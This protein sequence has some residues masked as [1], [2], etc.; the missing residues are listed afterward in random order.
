[1]FQLFEKI[2]FYRGQ[3]IAWSR[4]IFGNTKHRLEVNQRALK[5]LA[6]RGYNNNLEEISK[7]K[8]EINELLHQEEGFYWQRYRAIWLPAGDKNTKLFHRR[9]S[10]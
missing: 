8:E 3:L 10:Q 9:A 5:E 4:D 1:M 6:G 2:K 7:V